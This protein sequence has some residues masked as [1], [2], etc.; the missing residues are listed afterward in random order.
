MIPGVKINA[1]I[2]V[3]VTWKYSMWPAIIFDYGRSC[4]VTDHESNATEIE[5][6]V[7]TVHY[8]IALQKLYFPLAN[9]LQ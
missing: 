1:F 9:H 4:H 3:A 5:K 8:K 7:I 6:F 2:S